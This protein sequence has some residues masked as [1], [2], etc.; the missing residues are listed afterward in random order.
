VLVTRPPGPLES[1][2]GGGTPLALGGA[3]KN[4]ARPAAGFPGARACA[5]MHRRRPP[6]PD[7]GEA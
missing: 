6:L 5:A 3:R 4:Y 2:V 1:A 7:T